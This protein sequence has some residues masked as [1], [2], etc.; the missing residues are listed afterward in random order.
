MKPYT[1]IPIDL[2]QEEHKLLAKLEAKQLLREHQLIE[3]V[4][5][6]SS[7]LNPA[8]I[9]RVGE[10]FSEQ[11]STLSDTVERITL[12]YWER[13]DFT[14]E[15]QHQQLGDLWRFRRR[16]NAPYQILFSGHTDTV[17][18][19]DSPFQHAIRLDHLRLN[20]PGA[21][22]MKGG[23][24][25][26]LSALELLEEHPLANQIGWTL[27]L[28]PDEEIGSPGSAP[29]LHEE[30]SRHHLGLI[31]EPAL[32][33]GN[34]AGERKGS[35]NFTLAVRGKAAH[36][37]REPEKG[38]N[39]IN[40]VSEIILQL[41]QLN[42]ARPGLTLNTGMIHGGETTNKVPDL[43]VIKFNVR[44][45]QAEDA[46]WFMQHLDT[47]CQQYNQQEGYKI[48][49]HGSFGRMPKQL[50]KAHRALYQLI[51]QCAYALGESLNWQTTGGCCDGNNL[52]AAGLPNIDTLGVKGNFIHSADEFVYLPSL[53]ERA[54]LTALLLFQIASSGL[55]FRPA[56]SSGETRNEQK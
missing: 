6:N 31:Y 37:G 49:Y 39:A 12:P 19:K 47:L 16:S 23:I 40:K 55:P 22:D 32:P 21:A 34:L 10:W 53:I 45:T 28:N 5:I 25:V 42:H 38:R 44:I 27:L 46:A 17:F 48:E 13:M 26:I 36:A 51:Q 52:S 29:F 8:G 35:G 15:L 2:A 50:D 4:E 41:D 18:P 30:A 11:F 24:L 54:K 3:L 56:V 1:D 7:S 20:A 14:G 9:N 33:D 43:A